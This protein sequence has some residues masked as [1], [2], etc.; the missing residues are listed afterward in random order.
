MSVY[1]TLFVFNKDINKWEDVFGAFTRAECVEEGQE[2]FGQRKKIMKNDGTYVGLRQNYADLGQPLRD[3]APSN[4][5]LV[6]EAR[7]FPHPCDDFL[8]TVRCFWNGQFVVWTYN[9]EDTGCYH[10][11]YFGSNDLESEIAFESR[12]DAL[13]ENH[14]AM[15]VRDGREPMTLGGL[16]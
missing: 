16:F 1:Y 11:Q 12:V 2:Y 9:D 8:W 7:Q 3:L 15:I 13:E 4:G 14:Q 10:G 5:A 6:I